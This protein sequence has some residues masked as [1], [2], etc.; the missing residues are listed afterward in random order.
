MERLNIIQ[1]TKDAAKQFLEAQKSEQ[2]DFAELS[3]YYVKTMERLM[4]KEKN[5][6]G[7]YVYEETIRLEDLVSGANSKLSPDKR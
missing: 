3:Q 6:E 4:D 5:P 2:Q 7:L 1:K